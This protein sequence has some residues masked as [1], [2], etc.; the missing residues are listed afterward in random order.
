MLGRYRFWMDQ[1][2]PDE[3]DAS[4]AVQ[5]DLESLRRHAAALCVLASQTRLEIQETLRRYETAEGEA[6]R[7]LAEGREADARD[8]LAAL[9]RM[10]ADLDALVKQHETQRRA[11]EAAV[12]LYR[13]READ[14]QGSQAALKR[15]QRLEKGARHALSV[16]R[17]RIASPAAPASEGVSMKESGEGESAVQAAREVLSRPPL[18]ERTLP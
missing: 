18:S 9:D 8:R 6:K 10:E 11:A 13:R 15:T 16:S 7:M 14:W 5:A 17:H 4:P 12:E 3:A 2:P 1:D